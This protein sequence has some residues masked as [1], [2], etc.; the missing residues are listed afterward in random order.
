M[1]GEV[2]YV[3]IY[4]CFNEFFSCRIEFVIVFG[5]YSEDFFPYCSKNWFLFI[6]IVYIDVVL[7]YAAVLVFGSL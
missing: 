4:V 1:C 5:V 7:R 2:F 6:V 3:V